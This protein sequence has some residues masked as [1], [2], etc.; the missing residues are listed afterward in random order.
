M[1]NILFFHGPPP[2]LSPERLCRNQTD[3]GRG[4]RVPKLWNAGLLGMADRCWMETECFHVLGGPESKRLKDAAPNL[5]EASPLS[6]DR[7]L[8]GKPPT[9]P[10]LSFSEKPYFLCCDTASEGRGTG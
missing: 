5:W 9:R 10:P 2:S 1:G 8:P 6:F 4:R 3:E 7:P